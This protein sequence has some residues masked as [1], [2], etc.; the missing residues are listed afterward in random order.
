MEEINKVDK[1]NSL[2]RYLEVLKSSLEKGTSYIFGNDISLF[3]YVG[4]SST[5]SLSVEVVQN[6]IIR[7]ADSSHAVYGVLCD[8]YSGSAKIKI[9]S[10]IIV[11]HIG[12][13]GSALGVQLSNT[14]YPSVS[15]SIC[16]NTIDV[17]DGLG[18]TYGL[19]L[20]SLVDGV[21]AN[22]TVKVNGTGD[23]GSFHYGM[24][25]IGVLRSNF[26][27]NIVNLVN[28]TASDIGIKVRSGSNYNL[29][30]GNIITNAGVQISD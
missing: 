29:G 7:E 4:V 6:K 12:S 8:T 25:L 27:N 18:N 1:E 17:S 3:G 23:G 15:G 13:L 24:D 20:Y 2:E 19:L 22:N 16:N 21:V 11:F 9:D 26:S 28:G 14:G 30:I 10:N 5:D